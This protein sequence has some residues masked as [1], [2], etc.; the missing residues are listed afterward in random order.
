MIYKKLKKITR[1]KKGEAFEGDQPEAYFCTL[2]IG[3]PSNNEAFF[4]VLLFFFKLG[5]GQA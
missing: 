2:R 5:C 3:P 1:R 4:D